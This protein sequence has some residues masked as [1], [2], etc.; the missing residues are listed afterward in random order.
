M[1]T[2]QEVVSVYVK[3]VMPI[4]W[5]NAGSTKIAI[6]VAKDIDSDVKKAVDDTNRAVICIDADTPEGYYNIFQKM[7]LLSERIIDETKCRH[8]GKIITLR[9]CNY[10]NNCHEALDKPSSEV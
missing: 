2:I 3:Q 8:E 6:S 9:G 4:N 10:C 7:S 5:Q 1:K